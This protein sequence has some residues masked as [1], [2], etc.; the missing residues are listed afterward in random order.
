MAALR[1]PII[2]KAVVDTFCPPGSPY[3]GQI[4]SDGVVL[5]DAWETRR[6]SASIATA[7]SPQWRALAGASGNFTMPPTASCSA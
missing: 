5:R 6:R 7:I 2:A 3:S 1:R 4:V